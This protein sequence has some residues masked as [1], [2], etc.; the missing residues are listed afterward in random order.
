MCTKAV[1]IFDILHGLVSISVTRIFYKFQICGND[2]GIPK[3]TLTDDKDEQNSAVQDK[4][5][6]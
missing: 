5:E 3:Q 1:S 6:H 4:C 2:C